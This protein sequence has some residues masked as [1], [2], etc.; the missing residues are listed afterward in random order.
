M[1]VIGNSCKLVGVVLVRS[2]HVKHSMEV[3][4]TD[5]TDK[6]GTIEIINGTCLLAHFWNPH[7]EVDVS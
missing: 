5:K 2:N 7:G 1:Y 3:T 6:K 4:R